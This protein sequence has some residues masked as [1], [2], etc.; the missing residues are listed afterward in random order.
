MAAPKVSRRGRQPARSQRL[1]QR[2][3]PSWWVYSVAF[4]SLQAFVTKGS[5][6]CDIQVAARQRTPPA[7]EALREDM[8][9]T[10]GPSSDRWSLGLMTTVA[11]AVEALTIAM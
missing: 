8:V 6:L 11:A 2:S 1:P 10:S 4:C 9:H 3:P 7:E 5:G